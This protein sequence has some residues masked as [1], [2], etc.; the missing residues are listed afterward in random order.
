MALVPGG[1]FLMGTDS[2]EGYPAD[3]EGPARKVSLH[4]FWIDTLAVSNA[5]FAKFVG[6]V[7]Y[8]TEAERF[9]WSFVFGGFLPDDFAP[10]RGVADAP[11][12]RQVHGASWRHP[13]GPQSNIA[14]RMN[15]PVV[16]LSWND[17]LSYCRWAGKRLPSEAEWEYAARGGLEQ[18]RYPWGSRL[19]PNGE[20]RMNVWQGKFPQV[21][22]AQDGY[23]GTA[24][25]GEFPSNGY[26][27][28]NRTGNIWEWCAD[29]FSATFHRQG[30]RDNPPGPPSGERK[31]MRGGSYLCHRSY[32]FRYRV[33]ARSSNTP[34]SSTGN[35]GFRCVRDAAD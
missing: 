27:L 23:R 21:D 31:V 28:H 26:G 32:C 30:A 15:H 11:W 6:A 10:T 1:E 34:D 4:P 20:H 33:A 13:E 3:G 12:W 7:A 19:T 29:W 16:H 14:D 9:G 24:P 18:Q 2:R 22:T 35:L 5:H 25:V 8:V 17:A